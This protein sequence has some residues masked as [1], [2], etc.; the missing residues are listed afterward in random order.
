M[1]RTVKPK[2]I[3]ESVYRYLQRHPEAGDTLEGITRWWLEFERSE[4]Y[5]DEVSAAIESML[6]KGVVKKVKCGIRYLYKLNK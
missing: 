1:K 3:S 4:Q 2:K 6:Q 5:V